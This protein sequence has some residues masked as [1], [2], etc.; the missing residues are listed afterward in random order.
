[1]TTL[2]ELRSGKLLGRL[3]G[4]STASDG[5]R[6]NIRLPT[7]IEQETSPL[8][9]RSLSLISHITLVQCAGSAPLHSSASS[10]AI[11]SP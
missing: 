7:Q 9:A 11:K 8:D 10:A 4:F 1:M 5:D 2:P 6:S 3:S